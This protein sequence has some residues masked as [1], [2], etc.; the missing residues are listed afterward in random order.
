MRKVLMIGAGG[1]AHKCCKNFDG[2]QN[3][4]RQ[5]NGVFRMMLIS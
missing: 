4:V 3:N 1:V 5:N 2:W